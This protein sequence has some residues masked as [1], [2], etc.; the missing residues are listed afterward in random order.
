LANKRHKSVIIATSLERA[1]AIGIICYEADLRD[2]SNRYKMPAQTIKAGNAN[3]S[4]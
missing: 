2:L 1:V 4:P 3:L